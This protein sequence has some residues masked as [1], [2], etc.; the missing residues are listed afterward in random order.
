MKSTHHLHKFKNFK[1]IDKIFR[2]RSALERHKKIRLDKNERPSDFESNFINKIKS[3][4]N[5]NYLNAYPEIEPI[6][7][8]LSKKLRVDKE[9]LVLSA[10]SDMAI[11]N[12]FELLVRP[13]D[14]II[15]ISP[16]Y[17]MI[18]VYAKLF[19]ANQVNI[20]FNKKFELDVDK[21]IKKID[22]KTKLI[23]FANPNNPTGTII[24]K[25]HIVNILKKAKKFNC[26]V[27]VDECYYG[28]CN[29][30]TLPY[31]KKF[32]NL[33]ISRSFSKGYGLAGCRAGFLIA[34]KDTARR[35]YKFRPMYEINSFAV[36]VIKEILNDKIIFKKYLQETSKGK[37]YLIKNLNKLGFS[38]RNTHTNLLLVDFKTQKSKM[39]IW[40]SFKRKNILVM[41]RPYAPGCENYLGFT[42]GPVKYMKLVINNLIKFS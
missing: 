35:L 1:K 28:F 2:V 37:K 13:R 33:I 24:A 19:D 18:N 14:K 17:G 9:M 34:N 5:S 27:L 31:L 20:N 15:T 16:T 38:Y 21:L 30:T 22:Y 25:K 36:L 3:K 32:S 40:N 39:E 4:I 42:L 6:Y 26:Y 8:M 10:G 23:I 29:F 7:N 11:R 41:L 12:C